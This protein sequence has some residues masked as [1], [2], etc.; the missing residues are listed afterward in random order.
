MNGVVTGVPTSTVPAEGV[1]PWKRKPTI[2]SV[3][4]EPKQAT[5]AERKRQLAQ[6]AEMGVA[7]P[8]EFRG[9][10]AMAGDWQTVSESPLFDT[11]KA[12]NDTGDSKA[13]FLNIGVRKR[14]YEG[15]DEEDETGEVRAKRVWGSTTRS[16]PGL[17]PQ[18]D[19]LDFLL[20]KSSVPVKPN[21]EATSHA[22]R[23]DNDPEK[24]SVGRI[25]KQEPVS[26]R[27]PGSPLIKSED[28]D[29]PATAQE[30]PSSL[31]SPAI[32]QEATPPDSGIVFKKRKPKPIRNK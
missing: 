29:E 25:L 7:I 13:E 11:I 16:Y 3:D 10:M 23:G 1:A 30:A 31:N 4:S 6:L 27:T 21:E 20:G 19:E 14:K 32:K 12:E 9:E 15:Q 26:D 17:S 28:F 2:S 24:P 5:S 18:D 8:E 22:N